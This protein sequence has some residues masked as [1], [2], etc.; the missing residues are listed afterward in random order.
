MIVSCGFDAAKGDPIGKCDVTYDGY[1]YMIH[2]LM[3]LTKGRILAALEGGYSL[4]SL[5]WAS[6]SV[7]RVLLGENLPITNSLNKYTLE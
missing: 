2:R 1:A 3:S 4:E 7:I 6:E 5:K